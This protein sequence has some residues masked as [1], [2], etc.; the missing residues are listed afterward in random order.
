MYKKEFLC[1][2]FTFSFLTFALAA[3][4]SWNNLQEISHQQHIQVVQKDLKSYEGSYSSFD[5]ES[6]SLLKND[7]LIR[8]SRENVL[9]VSLRGPSQRKRHAMIGAL[10]GAGAGLGIGLLAA[11][12]DDEGFEIVSDEAVTGALVVIG[13]GAGAL[14]GTIHRAHD[15][16]TIYRA[17][18][19]DN[20]RGRTVACLR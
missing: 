14:I 15:Y 8:L 13:A 5:D 11:T 17:K 1:F 10:V 12:G 2:V 20:M 18:M 19:D 7:R 6:I 3:E 9:R 16:R 4:D